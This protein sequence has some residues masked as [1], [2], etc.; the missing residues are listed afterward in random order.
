MHTRRSPSN[1]VE[2]VK[3]ASLAMSLVH[4]P[5]GLNVLKIISEKVE[6]GSL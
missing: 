6:D 1:A 2:T 5:L 3:I 4:G